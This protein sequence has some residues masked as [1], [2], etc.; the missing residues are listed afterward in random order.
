MGASA[1][2][3]AGYG[4]PS[5]S[6]ALFSKDTEKILGAVTCGRNGGKRIYEAALAI[7]TGERAKGIPQTIHAYLS[8]AA[9]FAFTCERVDGSVTHG[10]QPKEK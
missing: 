8:L 3:F 4:Q 10:M 7:K 1:G 2:S 6:K 5:A 9:T